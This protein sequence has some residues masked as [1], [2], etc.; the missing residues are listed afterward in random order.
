MPKIEFTMTLEMVTE[1]LA[2]KTIHYRSVDSTMLPTEV[3][4]KSP[5]RYMTLTV[6]EWQ[7]MRNA[8]RYAG[9]H[10]MIDLI[11]SGKRSVVEIKESL[12]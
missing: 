5:S 4:I 12:K 9:M 3:V 2:G 6:E 11:E 10:E 8:A 1:L 7:E